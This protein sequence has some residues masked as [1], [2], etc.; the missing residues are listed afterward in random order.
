SYA[1]NSSENPVEKHS[2]TLLKRL[3]EINNLLHMSDNEYTLVLLDE[4]HS[5]ASVSGAILRM[6]L[7]VMT[8][9]R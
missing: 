9:K 8:L 3:S 2:N 4:I 1:A 7:I 5:V 6:L